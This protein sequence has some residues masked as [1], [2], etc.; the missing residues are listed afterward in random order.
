MKTIRQKMIAVGVVVLALAG[1]ASGAGL[2]ESGRLSRNIEDVLHDAQA[3]R[4]QM[5]ADMMH[6]ALRADALAALLA[7][8]PSSGLDA[9]AVAADLAEHAAVFREM[10][11]ANEAL[12]V[13][14][15]AAAVLKDLDEPLA[16]YIN[17]AE[18]LVGAA[19]SDRA[20][21]LAALPDFMEQFSV[22]EEAM[23]KAGDAIQAVS[24]R[25]QADSEAISAITQP[26]L[27]AVFVLSIV[28][29]LGLIVA[30]SRLVTLP[31]RRMSADMQRLADGDT[32]IEVAGVGR[33]DEIGQMAAAVA[34]FRNAAIE[35]RR[36]EKEA[37]AARQQAE[38]ERSRL[39]D[40]AEAAAQAR[41]REATAELAVG[42]R[43]LAEGDL[44]FD[45]QTRL[46]ADFEPLRHDLNSAVDKLGTALTTVTH[47]IG[48]VD[49]GAS[50]IFDNMQELSQRTERQ[51]STLEE[52]AAALEQLTVNVSTSANRA[53]EARTVAIAANESAK[54]SG[55]VVADA[56]QAMGRIEESSNRISNI[57][58]VID[59]I[60]FQTNLLALNAG[61]EAARAGEAGR[62][63]AVVAQEVREL[64]QRSATAA[65]EIKDLIRN[66]SA[67]VDNGVGLVSKTGEALQT[68]EEHIVTINAHMEAIATSSREQSSGLSEINTAIAQLDEV[69]QRN[70]AMAAEGNADSARLVEEA[71]ELRE[72]I[73]RFRTVASETAV[74][75]RPSRAA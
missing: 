71:G 60:A 48:R 40:E 19:A 63:F 64:A 5:Q 30:M 11:A 35:N 18:A 20:A 37:E 74:D 45:L 68:I 50:A 73:G 51:A 47:T 9:Q 53:A 14:P 34:V 16:R 23:E 10:I 67:E 58:G 25:T 3:L 4:N 27:K 8:D 6:D 36:L 66:A 17:G 15:Q 75:S 56:V 57:I 33:R 31:I 69:T 2:W 24:T 55:A 13:D 22:L 70:A 12:V 39:A 38:S 41:L 72:A 29:A 7:Q 52:T 44:A 43:R 61:V 28:F 49:K 1:G 62:G 46:G 65:R 32:T 54:S 21:A 26:A 42:L 59:E